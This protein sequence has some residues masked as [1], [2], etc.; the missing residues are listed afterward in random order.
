MQAM[1]QCV[2]GLWEQFEKIDFIYFAHICKFFL[3]ASFKQA[4]SQGVI[5]QI[6]QFYPTLRA[7]FSVALW[8]S[9]KVNAKGAKKLRRKYFFLDQIHTDI[10]SS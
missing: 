7:A 1:S 9:F 2:D 6:F 8:P 10:G 5:G 3:Y 4:M